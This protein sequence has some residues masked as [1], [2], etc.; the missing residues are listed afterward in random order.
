M[1]YM[2]TKGQLFHAEVQ[3]SGTKEHKNIPSQLFHPAIPQY[4]APQQR[5]QKQTVEEP[6]SS[7][8]IILTSPSAILPKATLWTLRELV[9]LYNLCTPH[10]CNPVTTLSLH[11]SVYVFPCP[12]GPQSISDHL[13]SSLTSSSPVLLVLSP[14]PK[15]PLKAFLCQ[16]I[17]SS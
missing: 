7:L 9:N 4:S 1:Q 12:H 13:F 8:G 10:D 11:V 15:S 17:S 2:S 14:Q 6:G 16:C 5:N 3:V